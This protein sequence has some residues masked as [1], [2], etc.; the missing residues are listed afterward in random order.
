[1]TK[2]P[3]RT[4]VRKPRTPRTVGVRQYALAK[5]LNNLK[6]VYAQMN[7]AR[8]VGLPYNA[9]AYA[10]NLRAAANKVRK[11]MK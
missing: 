10:R 3:P 7:F 4:V 6:G 8:E 2:S 5:A 9:N 1:M 11:L